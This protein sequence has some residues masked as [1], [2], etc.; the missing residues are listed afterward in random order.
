MSSEL[1]SKV[2]IRVNVK[3]SS[4]EQNK[5]RLNVLINKE[6]YKYFNIFD[7]D[8]DKLKDKLD[9]LKYQIKV[10]PKEKVFLK[11]KNKLIKDINKLAFSKPFILF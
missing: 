6:N 7:F 11:A 1:F 10:K 3:D 9:T 2:S 8:N 5:D 4:I